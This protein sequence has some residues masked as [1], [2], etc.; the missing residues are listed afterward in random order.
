MNIIYNH[1]PVIVTK[2]QVSQEYT[3]HLNRIPVVRCNEKAMLNLC[4][5]VI[6]EYKKSED[7]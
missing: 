5:A 6:D 1:E 7:T 2:S 3:I 4:N